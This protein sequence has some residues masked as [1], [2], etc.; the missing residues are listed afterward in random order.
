MSWSSSKV[1]YHWTYF[2]VLPVGVY[3]FTNRTLEIKI[4]S[5]NCVNIFVEVY[6]VMIQKDPDI[7]NKDKEERF[8]SF[9]NTGQGV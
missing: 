5:I 4:D 7:C 6:C 1:L 2:C 8:M 3:L 9:T